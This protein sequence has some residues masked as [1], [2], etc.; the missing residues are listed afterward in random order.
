[1]RSNIDSQN[2]ER[3]IDN[4]VVKRSDVLPSE[5]QFEPRGLG[6][7]TAV[8][9]Q[10]SKEGAWVHRALYAGLALLRGH[11]LDSELQLS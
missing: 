2:D 6:L 3:T 4:K 8:K 10:P 1:M 9:E 11:G 7:R 5:R